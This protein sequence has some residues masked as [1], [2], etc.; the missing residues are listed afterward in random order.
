MVFLDI[1]MPGLNG[2]EVIERM[3]PDAAGDHLR[4]RL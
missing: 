4:H 1:A 2:F 3:I